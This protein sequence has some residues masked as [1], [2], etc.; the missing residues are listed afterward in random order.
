MDMQMALSAMQTISDVDIRDRVLYQILTQEILSERLGQ[1]IDVAARI[2]TPTYQALAYGFLGLSQRDQVAYQGLA[3]MSAA[4]ANKAAQA[5][6]V[7]AE[8]SA[9]M[10]EL[11]RFAERSGDAQQAGQYFTESQQLAKKLV[12]EN[13]NNALAILAANQAQALHFTDAQQTL[14]E[15]TGVDIHRLI[16]N[17]QQAANIGL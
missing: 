7:V 12:A 14:T 2:K 5:I 15:V 11:G 8:K 9:V 4:Q 10:G 17:W 16:D 1:A 3:A 13:R 6:P